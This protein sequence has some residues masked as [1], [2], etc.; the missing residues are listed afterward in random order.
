MATLNCLK[1][2]KHKDTNT[3]SKNSPSELLLFS[4]IQRTLFGFHE[5]SKYTWWPRRGRKGRIMGKLMILAVVTV[6]TIIAIAAAAIVLNNQQT[7]NNN[8]P[9]LNPTVSTSTGPTPAAS[10]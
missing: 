4:Q 7:N 3:D 9:T 2:Q 5:A 6:A 8:S 10:R 1:D